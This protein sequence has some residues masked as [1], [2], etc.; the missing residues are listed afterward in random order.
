MQI[1]RTLIWFL[2]IH[3]YFSLT[4]L[5]SIGYTNI[6]FQLVL[7]SMTVFNVIWHVSEEH[8][9]IVGFV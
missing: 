2:S 8:Y 6:I 7:I 4:L 5:L 9:G 1:V 3:V